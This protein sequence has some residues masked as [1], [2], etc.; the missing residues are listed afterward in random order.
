MWPC[1]LA[2]RLPF[3]GSTRPRPREGG[4]SDAA[5][6]PNRRPTPPAFS[7]VREMGCRNRFCGPI[8]SDHRMSTE[9]RPNDDPQAAH[10]QAFGLAARGVLA[11]A[12]AFTRDVSGHLAPID[13]ARIYLATAATLMIG[14]VG[15]PAAAALLRDLADALERGDDRVVRN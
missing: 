12:E 6:L 8:P 10:A 5:S 11:A 3:E 2:K 9:H 13:C 4:T 7:R 14:T 1:F 15:G